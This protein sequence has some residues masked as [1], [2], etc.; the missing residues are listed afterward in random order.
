MKGLKGGDRKAVE[1]AVRY[2]F[3]DPA[4]LDLAL[5]HG[6]AGRRLDNQRLEFL[7]DALLNF[8][9]ARLIYLEQPDWPEGTL[10]SV[11]SRAW[12]MTR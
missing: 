3:G 7:G 1:A 11:P 9:V 6:S 5:T 10:S 8:C 4:L 12:V 2:Q